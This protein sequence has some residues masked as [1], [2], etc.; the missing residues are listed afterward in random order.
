MPTTDVVTRAQQYAQTLNPSFELE[1]GENALAH[2]SAVQVLLAS[3]GADESSQALPFL[4]AAWS[5]LAQ[6]EA[7]IEKQFGKELAKLAASARKL[8]SIQQT[9]REKQVITPSENQSVGGD[10]VELMRKML[11]AFSQDL[12]V[13][14]L[15]LA[16]RL[17]TLRYFAAEKRQPPDALARETLEVMAPVANRLGV[18]QLKWELE[19]LGFRFTEP[20]TYKRVA[21]LLDEKR[22]EREATI[23]RSIAQL[24]AALAKDSVSATIAGRPK[25]IYSI[26]KK[27]RG[28]ALE[29]DDLMDVR[30]LRVLVADVKTCYAAL[31]AVHALWTPIEREFDDYIARPKGN[32]YQSLHTVVLNDEGQTIEVQI[33]TE[34]MHQHAEFGVAAHW[35]YKEGGL[36]SADKTA[37]QSYDQKIAIARQLL[38]M[39]SELSGAQGLFDDRIYVLTPQAAI[40]ELTA[41]ATAIDFAYT[42][43]TSL[44]HRCRGAK[45]DG[46]V[47]PLNTPLKNGQ[48][49][50]ITAVKEGNPSRDWLN[51]ELGFV[52]SSRAKAKIR[53][54]FNSLELDQ[55]IAEG[56][57]QVEK[58]LQRLGKT[59]QN[60]EALAEKLGFKSADALFEM[61]G[62]DE[63]SLRNIDVALEAV[64]PLAPAPDVLLKKAK[65]DGK[66][67]VLVV[68]MGSL[69]TQL[70]QC[71][72]PVPPDSI[73]GF[74]TRTKGVSV[75]RADC[76]NF[77]TMAATSPGRVIPVTW[78]GNAGASDKDTLYCVDVFVEAT[79]RQGLLRDV[80]DVFSKEKI[81][82]V[83]VNTRSIKH[84]AYMTFSVEIKR[85][86]AL[87]KALGLIAEVQGV[88]RAVRK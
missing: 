12:R 82:V 45:V 44:G 26:Y 80:S 43:H 58:H 2:A 71:C 46:R 34:A 64:A 23:A 88:T 7:A 38:A 40:V 24:E 78:S 50:E 51:T 83:G 37:V 10:H 30:A 13:V 52:K 56:R 67:G 4:L 27:M 28:K 76:A 41:G 68:G 57:V 47:V 55:T 11:L 20:A 66:G 87:P 25:H 18:W 86:E 1:T 48:T 5:A 31:G 59:A 15:R 85:A 6:P 8:I 29:F 69:L 42:L 36:T 72:K 49:I 9:T 74:V 79:D 33:R 16:S 73:L 63:F 32:G 53:A 60:L 3:M 35:A 81:N 22:A 14:L 61:V 70:A 77:G 17:Q 21:K 84:T 39:Q 62:K 75:H 65:S 54:W 19:D